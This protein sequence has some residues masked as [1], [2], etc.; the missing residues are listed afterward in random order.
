MRGSI[1]KRNGRYN[2]VYDLP[3]VWDEQAKRRKRH[4][5]WERVPEPNTKKHA[6][7]LLAARLTELDRGEYSELKPIKF[8][9]FAD[10]WIATY[11]EGQVRPSTLDRY[12]SLFATHLL[13][14]FG[15]CLLPHLTVETVQRFRATTESEGQSPQSVKHML[16]LLRQMLN[17]AV[18][19]S[20]LR[21]N[22]ALKVRYPRVPKQEMDF[23]TPAEARLLLDH[24]PE[25]WTALILTAI[26]TGMRLGELLAM[27]WAHLDWHHARYTVRETL[28]RKSGKRAVGFGPVK[29]DSSAQTVDLTVRCLEALRRH[30]HR[31]SQ[32]QL[33]QRDFEDHGLIFCTD[34][35]TPLNDRNVVQRV[36][37]PAL[38]YGGLR[39]IRFHDLRHTCASLL[40][41]QGENVKYIQRQLRHA[42]SQITFDRYGHLLPE[43]HQEA[44]RRLDDTLFGSVAG[45]SGL[46]AIAIAHRKTN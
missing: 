17:H 10:L 3:P 1:Q 42:S 31:Q 7:R 11:A 44:T 46:S 34:L 13:P 40:I 8:R 15:D 9:E 16:R 43:S 12:R 30:R 23:L 14:A 28:V 4:Q 39:R 6:E 33:A 22:P 20:Y 24:V 35:G 45:D 19:W 32:T 5:K 25:K 26:T 27:K 41:A 21:M 36:L 29:T 18:D 37:E 38:K 2:I